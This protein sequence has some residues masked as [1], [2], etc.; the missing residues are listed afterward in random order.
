[1]SESN[2]IKLAPPGTF[3]DSFTEILRS[4]ARALLSVSAL[5]CNP[6]REQYNP[7]KPMTRGT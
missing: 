5:A 2:I 6:R 4:G 1:M 3:T 7:A